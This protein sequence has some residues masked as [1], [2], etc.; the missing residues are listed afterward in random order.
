MSDKEIARL[1]ESEEKYRKMIESAHDAIF[2]IDVETAEI[3]EANP[4]AEEMTG[5]S[6]SELIGMKVWELHPVDEREAARCFFEEVPKAGKGLCAD[7]DFLTKSGERLAIDVSASVITYGNRRIIQ[8]ICRDITDR[9]KLEAKLEK[10]KENLEVK[11]EERTRELRQKQAQLIQSEK[12]AALGHLV[13]GVAHE[14]NT[15][16]GALKSNNDLLIRA[17]SKM[18]HVVS[19]PTTPD[20][21]RNHPQL[22]KIL[23]NI[24]DLNAI[25][26][27][28]MERI[29]TIVRSLRKFARLDEAEQDKIDIHEGLESTLTLVHH[30]LKNRIQVHT[31]FA[32]VP[33]ITCYPNQINQVFMNI[34]VNAS[35][36]IEGTG[37]I[38]IKTYEKDDHVIVEIRD[39][40]KGIPKENIDRIFD[41]GFTTKGAGVGTG[42]GL[43]I[44][45]QIIEDHNG[46]IEIDSEVGKGTTFRIILP[47]R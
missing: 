5:Y 38:F 35:Q 22:G 17:L 21:I 47:V 31:D 19:D 41:P 37:D 3:L 1:R 12:M 29:V 4:M 30:E 43:S 11:V 32:A 39:T 13:A 16:L 28:A 2:A 18:K 26:K 10:A 6:A 40:G 9:K 14:I 33:S 44:V 45:Y 23:A 7:L 24:E 42:L 27:S 36:A 25:N 46:K 8:R 20:T 34:L 15:P